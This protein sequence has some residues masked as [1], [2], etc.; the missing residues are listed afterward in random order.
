MRITILAVTG[1]QPDWLGEAIEE[2][3]KRLRAQVRLEMLDLKAESRS[4]GLT[5]EALLD[6]ERVR[7]AARI[8]AGSPARGAPDL[9][10]LSASEKIR[11]GI[12]ARE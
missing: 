11:M 12:S 7:I 4:R 8:P 5:V 10:S 2:Y 3:V 9:E 6:A 1:K